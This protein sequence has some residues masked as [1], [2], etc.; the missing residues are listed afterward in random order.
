LVNLELGFAGVMR[1]GE[2]PFSCSKGNRQRRESCASPRRIQAT[3]KALDRVAA[4]VARWRLQSRGWTTI[5][6][7]FERT[8][9]QGLAP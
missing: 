8:Y 6:A 1:V 5:G 9:R 2:W 7:G 3:R 4:D